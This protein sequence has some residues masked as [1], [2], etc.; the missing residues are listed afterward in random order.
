MDISILRY[1]DVL[2]GFAVAMALASSFVTLM[3]QFALQVTHKR[4]EF[5]KQGL[6][7]LLRRA[8]PKLADHAETIAQAVLQ[9]DGANSSAKNMR[10]V[11]EREQLIRRLLEFAGL[12]EVAT[13]QTSG[14]FAAA[15]RALADV[16]GQDEAGKLLSAIDD[17]AFA[18]EAADPRQA[19]HIIHT[20]AI[21][22]AS[23]DTKKEGRQF[24]NAVMTR[25]DTMGDHLT[26]AFTDHSRTV[27]F[28]FSLLVALALPLDAIGLLQRLS[29]DDKLRAVFVS[30][31]VEV[32]EEAAPAKKAEASGQPA[33][34]GAGK[35]GEEKKTVDAPE[36]KGGQA[37]TGGSQE[38]AAKEPVGIEQIKAAYG[39]LNDPKLNLSPVGWWPR[40][41]YD[42]AKQEEQDPNHPW[43]WTIILQT[44]G[45]CFLSALLMSIGAPF[46]F[47]ALKNLLKLRPSLAKA[48]DDARESR[49]KDEAAPK[50]G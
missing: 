20:R 4:S 19:T 49:R 15:R 36:G 44:L 26:A 43:K 35:A 24:I 50:T 32:V 8:D 17:K 41:Y 1:L 34:D 18:L 13:A 23:A 38:A 14:D 7:A 5:L 37:D 11:I 29:S 40:I 42:A 45:G 22:E 31:A 16:L 9:W 33:Q 10:E 12:S 46:W 6:A 27:T 39:A 3:T 2:I 47:E 28:L 25:F 48:D 30:K 21:F